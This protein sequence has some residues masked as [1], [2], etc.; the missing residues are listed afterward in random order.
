MDMSRGGDTVT[1]LLWAQVGLPVGDGAT[2]GLS[3]AAELG[4]AAR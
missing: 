4:P 1:P 2:R 3:A